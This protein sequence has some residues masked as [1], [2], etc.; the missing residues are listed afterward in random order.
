MRVWEWMEMELAVEGMEVGTVQVGVAAMAVTVE[1]LAAMAEAAV[2]RTL[3][4][5]PPTL[6]CLQQ[7][8][9]QKSLPSD[10]HRSTD[11]TW[12][13][14]ARLKQYQIQSSPQ[15]RRHSPRWCWSSP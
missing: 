1:S 8:S 15:S 3:P 5:T 7:S 12:Q 2:S 9:L 10:M 13:T 6:G 11:T 4:P 14:L